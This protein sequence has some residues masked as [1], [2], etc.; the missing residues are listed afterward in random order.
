MSPQIN[1]APGSESTEQTHVNVD[2][3]TPCRVS[4]SVSLLTLLCPTTEVSVLEA[5][6]ILESE[7]EHPVHSDVPEPNRAYG[8]HERVVLPPTHA[9]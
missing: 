1:R 9:H 6:R 8:Q 4:A 2:G 7:S 3:D 5:I